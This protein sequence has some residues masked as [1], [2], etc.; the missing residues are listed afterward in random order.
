MKMAAEERVSPF[1]LPPLDYYKRYSEENVK[2][3]N[4]PE[5]P[6]PIRGE[7]SIFGASFEVS[8]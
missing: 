4:A 7:Y 3:G 1:P 6:L 2:L 8:M 5:P